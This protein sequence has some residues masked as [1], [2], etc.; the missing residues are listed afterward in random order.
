MASVLSPRLLLRGFLV[1]VGISVL[2]YA[3]VLLYGN[4]LAAFIHALGRIH[5]AWILVGLA[6]ASMDWFG[7]GFRNWVLV[8]HVPPTR[9][10]S[11]CSWRAAWVRGQ[12]T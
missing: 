11:G 9:R 7:G 12:P 10:S 5:W 1:F 8:R 2:G 4:N 6:L 3:G